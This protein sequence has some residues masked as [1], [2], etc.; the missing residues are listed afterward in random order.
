MN[1]KANF[2]VV[3]YVLKFSCPQHGAAFAKALFRAVSP[4]LFP[5]HSRELSEAPAARPNACPAIMQIIYLHECPGILV[6][7]L[8]L[9]ALAGAKLGVN[10]SAGSG[11]R[12]VPGG[13]AKGRL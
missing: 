8:A 3:V 4:C 9:L 12:V 10:G 6:H 2:C 13:A 7:A 11:G 5:H 1:N